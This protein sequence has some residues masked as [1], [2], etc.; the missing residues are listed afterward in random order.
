MERGFGG[1]YRGGD[2]RAPADV[3]SPQAWAGEKPLWMAVFRSELDR[4]IRL[5]LTVAA[6]VFLV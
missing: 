1:T 6:F 3:C 4:R 5:C 2:E